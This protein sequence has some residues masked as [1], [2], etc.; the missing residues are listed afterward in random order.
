LGRSG[1]ASAVDGREVRQAD[2]VRCGDHWRTTGI[3]VRRTTDINSRTLPGRLYRRSASIASGVKSIIPPKLS[4]CLAQK[5]T[6]A[7]RGLK[8]L[9]RQ[10]R[11]Q[12][13]D[14]E[15]VVEILAES[16]VGYGLWQPHVGSRDYAD[17]DVD[18]LAAADTHDLT[19][20][21]EAQQV[22]LQIDG[23]IADLIEKERAACRVFD[24][25]SGSRA[26]PG[27]RALFIA[28][29]FR[30]DEVGR[31]R[32]TVHC[33]ERAGVP[34]RVL[35]DGTGGQFLAGAAFPR[36]QD[37]FVGHCV[38][39]QHLHDMLDGGALPNDLGSGV[40]GES[41]RRR[42]RHVGRIAEGRMEAA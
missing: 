14:V 40:D 39:F 35:M 12:C 5:M 29:Q 37:R 21:Q 11:A 7:A 6:R 10:R 36:D 32:G 30:G 2:E 9:A 28:E 19:F 20:L 42:R 38:T 22:A 3:T 23:H 13:Q 34:P 16:A 18:R 8:A 41:R 25:S 31:N 1:T 24:L 27:E 17:I 26:S 4:G 15:P 33:D